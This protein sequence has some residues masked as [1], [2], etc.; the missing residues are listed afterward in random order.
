[1]A[2]WFENDAFWSECYAFMFGPERWEAARDEVDALLAL[3]APAPGAA[4]LDVCCGPGRH[5]I[6]LGRRG[7]AVTGVDR[8]ARYLAQAGE[9]APS[10]EWVRSDVREFVREGAF[11]LALNLYSSFGYFADAED[12]RRVL[13][14]VRASLRPGGRFVVE[15]KGEEVL[16]R[17]FQ[18]KSWHEMEDGAFLLVEHE[19][20]DGA[21]KN[22]W[23]VLR[24]AERHEFDFELRLYSAPSLAGALEEAGFTDVKTYGWF[25]GRPY[26]DEAKRLVAVA[27]A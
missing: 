17:Q 5:A 2:G 22:R 23:I 9:A 13:R 14:N 11:D 10:L 6:E 18:H 25:D 19:L 7:F 1:M 21:V 8:N 3:L 20:L 27:T 4:V 12:D 24:E 15:L 26:D 16:R